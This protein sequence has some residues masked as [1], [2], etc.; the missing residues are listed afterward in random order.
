[1]RANALGKL[2]GNWLFVG[3]QVPDTSN[4]RAEV[5][6]WALPV[7]GGTPRFAFGYE[8]SLGGA[9]E[10]IF[11]NT[12]YL[13][14]QFSP[15]GTRVVVSVGGRLVVV[16]L[17]S[18]QTREIGVSGFFPS[19]SKDGSRI[20][21]LFELPV[22][23]VVPPESAIGVVPASGG[24]VKQLAVVGY[25]HQSVE[26]SPDGSMLIVAEPDR[27]AIIDAASGNVIRTIPETAPSGSSFAH[28]R[29]TAPQIAL[30]VGRCDR[31]TTQLLTL[32]DPSEPFV[33]QLDTGKGCAEPTFRDPRWSPTRATE[34]LYVAIR[35][36]PGRMPSEYRAHVLDT[37]SGKDIALPFAVREATWTWDGERIAYL[38]ASADRGV[39]DGVGLSRRDGTGSR[40]LLKAADRDIF[41]SVASVAY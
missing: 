19:W 14:R 26:W 12:P 41:F 39:G 3:K 22:G 40:S 35:A 38:T 21:F 1:V 7:D 33:I 16:D 32:A 37:Y 36:E 10:G 11:D 5:Q 25:A 24:P 4:A 28:W 27:T 6:I 9:P 31:T 29:L 17:I 8:V 15:D 23:N 13:R 20:A 30:A 18:G 34:V 2:T